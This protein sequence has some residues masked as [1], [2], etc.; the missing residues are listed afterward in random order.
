MHNECM[1]V[2]I[3]IR[4]VSETTR[5][6]LVAQAKRR[7][8]SL[9]AYLSDVLEQHA[10]IEHNR[11]VFEELN[12]TIEKARAENNDPEHFGLSAD[13]ILA[14]VQETRGDN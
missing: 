11:Q 7:G 5:N 10:A 4:N 13:Q 12:K 14:L 8:Q 2:S 1:A 3:Q 9:Q 6:N